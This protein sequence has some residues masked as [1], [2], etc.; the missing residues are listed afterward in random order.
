MAKWFEKTLKYNPGEKSLKAPIA[1]YLNLE[2]LLKKE[3]SCQNNTE[4]SDTEKKAMHELSGWAMLTKFSFDKT[5]DKL[6][7]YRGKDCMERLCKKLKD[8]AMKIINFEEKKMIPLI[9]EEN[10]SYEE[11]EACHTCIENFCTDVDDK[12]YKTKKRLKDHCHFTGKIRGAA[13]S[14]CNLN[15]KVP[16]NIPI[17]IHNASYDFYFI[18]NQLAKEFKGEPDCI[19]ENME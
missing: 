14:I 4:K 10:K 13:H 18:I 2:C 15:Y 6:G 3:Q 12:N 9:D 17:V 7:Y 19:G 16:K 1:I 11:Q 5:E 8:H